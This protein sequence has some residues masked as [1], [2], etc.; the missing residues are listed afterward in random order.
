MLERLRFYDE[1]SNPIEME[2]DEKMKKRYLRKLK[3][4]YHYFKDSY[5]RAD[6][7]VDINR[8]P[9]N[10]IP[11]LVTRELQK[12]IKLPQKELR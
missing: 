5:A 8:V 2:L 1:D 3:G 9:L 12:T 7:T 11:A 6:F 4:D 10:E